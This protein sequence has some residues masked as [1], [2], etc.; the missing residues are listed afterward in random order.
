MLQLNQMVKVV[1]I[2]GVL[3]GDDATPIMHYS[4]VLPEKVTALWDDKLQPVTHAESL[5]AFVAKKIWRE[6][7]SNYDVIIAIDNIAARQSL[8]RGSSRF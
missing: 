4:E 2:G 5:G 6:E 3:L 8:I 1:T 7:L